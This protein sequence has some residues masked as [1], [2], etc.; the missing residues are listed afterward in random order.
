MKW[1]MKLIHADS[2]QYEE[3]VKKAQDAEKT[4]FDKIQSLT[5]GLRKSEELR[6]ETE[7]L[8]NLAANAQKSPP[9]DVTK[10]PI[11]MEMEMEISK[12]ERR[13]SKEAYAT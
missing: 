13:I 9:V 8:L 2:N 12:F 5:T 1:K 6:K 11:F 3:I 10:D 7:D 4:A